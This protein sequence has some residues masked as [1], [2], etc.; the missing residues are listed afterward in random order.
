MVN[1]IGD[2]ILVIDTLGMIV[3]CNEAAMEML[4]TVLIGENFKE[5]I[6]NSEIINL[7]D[8]VHSS[9]NAETREINMDPQGNLICR[10][11]ISPMISYNE[12]IGF[13]C[14]LMDITRYTSRGTETM[15]K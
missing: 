15:A 11:V 10:I 12:V 6:T 4:K 14:T 7:F 13:V 9:G 8:V 1:T 2:A 3:L 5:A